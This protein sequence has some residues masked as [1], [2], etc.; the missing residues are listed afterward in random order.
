MRFFTPFR[1]TCSSSDN[2]CHGFF[3]VFCLFCYFLKMIVKKLLQSCKGAP[4]LDNRP[5]R[6]EWNGILMSAQKFFLKF[7]FE[8]KG[9]YIGV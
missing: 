2:V 8:Y 3:V 9:K 5:N 4:K 1:M 6:I 7:L